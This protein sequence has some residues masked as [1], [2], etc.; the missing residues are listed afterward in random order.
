M[1]TWNCSIITT[2]ILFKAKTAASRDGKEK[3][4]SD[5]RKPVGGCFGQGFT[6]VFNRDPMQENQMRV[7]EKRTGVR[8][9]KTR[10]AMTEENRRRRRTTRMLSS[11]CGATKTARR[12]DALD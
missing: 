3:K 9:K 4:T 8:T 6:I 2:P 5:T 12:G 10:G 1:T 11:A 7:R